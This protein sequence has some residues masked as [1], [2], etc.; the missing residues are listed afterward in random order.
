[1]DPLGLIISLIPVLLGE[2]FVLPLI[3]TGEANLVDHMAVLPSRGVVPSVTF[4]LT[5]A[6]VQRTRAALRVALRAAFMEIS[7]EIILRCTC[8]AS[9]LSAASSTIVL[10]IVRIATGMIS[11]MRQLINSLCVEFLLV[12]SASLNFLFFPSLV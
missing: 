6:V 11:G 7:F 3:Q 12:V 1:M 10:S 2:L 9:I 8:K 5:S 4:Q